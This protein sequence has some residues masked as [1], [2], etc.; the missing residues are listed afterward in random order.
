MCHCVIVISAWQEAVMAKMGFSLSTNIFFSTE[1][2]KGYSLPWV[3]HQCMGTSG[4]IHY[5][6]LQMKAIQDLNV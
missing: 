3:M 5:V 2:S 6:A 4:T 1:G